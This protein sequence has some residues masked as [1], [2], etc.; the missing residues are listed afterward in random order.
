[1][2]PKVSIIILNWNGW[3]DTI[4]CLESL[5]QVTYPNYDV[6]VVDN[7]S[8]DESIQKI[9]EYCQGKIKIESTFLEY[10]QSNKPIKVIEYTK[11]ETDNIE[12]DHKFTD[13]PSNQKLVLIKNK[14][15]YGFAEGNNIGITYSLKVLKPSW[16]MILNNDT[17]VDKDI[18]KELINFSCLKPTA[19]LLGSKNYNYYKENTLGTSGGNLNYW[20][21]KLSGDFCG[22]VDVGQFAKPLERDF[23]CGTCMMIHKEVLEKNGFIDPLFFF[24][25]YEDV[26]LCLRGIH[27]GYEVYSVPSAR[28]WHKG[29]D[30]DTKQVRTSETVKMYAH[31][32]LRNRLIIYRRYCSTPQ[33]LSSLFFLPIILMSSAVNFIRYYRSWSVMK[34]FLKGT[35]FAVRTMLKEEKL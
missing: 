4:E 18:L 22:E 10:D 29:E 1:M 19:K 5:Y 14:K 26:D 12:R 30:Q 28:L 33:F 25:G 2:N 34:S 6:V 35:I 11:G 31:Y 20:T 24:G 8:K 9:N 32:A 17:V 16:I 21:G 15:N 3:K 13:A 7:G 27:A 23:V